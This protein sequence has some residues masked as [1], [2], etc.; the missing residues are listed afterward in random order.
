MSALSQKGIEKETAPGRYH[1]SNGLHLKISPSGT[2]A[3]ILR[4]QLNGKRR[5]LGLGAFPA[6][7]LAAARKAALELRVQINNGHDPLALRRKSN[8]QTVTVES[9]AREMIE[10]NKLGWS[11]KHAA[12]WLNSLRDH[13]FPVIG[14][15]PIDQ[16]DTPAVMSVLDPIWRATPETARRV[17]NRLERVIDYAKA[18]GHRVGD[19]PARW[20]GHLQNVLTSNAAP[21]APLES[22]PYSLLPSFMRK[23]EA[24]SSMAARC[25]QFLILTACRSSEAMGATWDEIDFDKKVWNIP[26]ER[27]K[28]GEAHQIPLSEEALAILKDTNSRGRSNFIFPGKNSD[29]ILANNALRRLMI[30]LDFGCTPHGFRATFRTWADEKTSYSYELCE[31]SLAHV[32]GTPTSRAYVRGNQLEKRRP[33]MEKWAEFA[34]ERVKPPPYSPQPRPNTDTHAHH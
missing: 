18:H 11:E 22:L 20:R 27:M 28:S 14:E 26:A 13:V 3:W 23:L 32:V 21:K 10:R 7:S 34:M 1:D 15:M 19:N 29:S 16:V 4:Y 30:K 24:E 25:A 6:V 33:L 9:A 12:Q 5:D 31:I 8:A 2:K 17:R